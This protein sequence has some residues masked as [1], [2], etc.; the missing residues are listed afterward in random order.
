MLR[1]LASLLLVLV[2]FVVVFTFISAYD[3][4]LCRGSLCV[5]V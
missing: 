1:S 3:V 5:V 4:L 2:L